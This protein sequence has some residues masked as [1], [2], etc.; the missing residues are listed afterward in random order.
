[1]IV[2]F[3]NSSYVTVPVLSETVYARKKLFRHLQGAAP[4]DNQ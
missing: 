3:M 2:E 1:M 4:S